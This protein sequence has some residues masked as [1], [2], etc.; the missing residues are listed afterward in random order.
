MDWDNKTQTGA[1]ATGV[2][3]GTL[4]VVVHLQPLLPDSEREF[5]VQGVGPMHEG[6]RQSNR[7]AGYSGCKLNQ[8]AVREGAVRQAS[9]SAVLGKTRRTE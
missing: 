3:E 6:Q 8:R 4:R 9:L 1:R 2:E 7:T 5:K